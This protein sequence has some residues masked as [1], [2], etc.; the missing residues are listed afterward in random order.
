MNPAADAPA[1]ML[2]LVPVAVIYES[3]TVPRAID[4]LLLVLQ[5]YSIFGGRL[6]CNVSETRLP[7]LTPAS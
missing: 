2:P 1:A 4:I 5:S 7:N 6:R 3:R